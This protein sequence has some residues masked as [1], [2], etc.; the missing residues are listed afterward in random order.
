MLV[1]AAMRDKPL[2][3]MAAA[4]FPAFDGVV[5]TRVPAERCAPAES[6][7]IGGGGRQDLV[8]PDPARALERA[9]ALAG[10]GGSVVVAGS[11][12][13]VG[14]VMGALGMGAGGR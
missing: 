2:E 5:A 7:P 8:E 6:I 1:F 4:L 14:H 13:L 11:L 10:T 12:Y 3:E 9:T